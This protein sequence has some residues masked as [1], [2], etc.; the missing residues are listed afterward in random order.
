MAWDYRV[1]PFS[2][3]DNSLFFYTDGKDFRAL[4]TELEILTPFKM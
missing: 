3:E 4:K 2:R 1:I